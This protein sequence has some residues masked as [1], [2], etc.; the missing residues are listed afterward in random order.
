LAQLDNGRVVIDSGKL[1]LYGQAK[2]N[3]SAPALQV[4]IVLTMPSDLTLGDMQVART[5]L[6]I[7]RWKLI[8]TLI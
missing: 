3:V 8:A 4:D 7:I 5:A 2:A 6:A 1:S